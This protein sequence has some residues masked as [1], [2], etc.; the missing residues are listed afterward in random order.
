MASSHAL[1]EPAGG[2]DQFIAANQRRNRYS[3]GDGLHSTR[4]DTEQQTRGPLSG[5]KEIHMRIR[6]IHDHGIG[7]PQASDQ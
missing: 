7:V 5:L 3:R 1:P 6:V 2:R 4:K